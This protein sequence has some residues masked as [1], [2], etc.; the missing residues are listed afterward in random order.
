MIFSDIVDKIET[1]PYLTLSRDCPVKEAADQV[2]RSPEIRGIYVLDTNQ[3]LT[4]YLSLGILI[5]HV[6]A[7]QRKPHLHVRSLLTTI[8][9]ETVADIM[10]RNII[11][12]RPA[13][14]LE[15]VLDQM[16]T[17]NMKQVPI[18]NAHRQ[19]VT[20]AGILDIWKWMQ[21]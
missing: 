11:Y 4:G 18:V 8:T 17:R 3:C 6:V 10:E 2:I 14:T 15:S 20:A 21:R 1:V 16:L 9:A 7:A 5:R 13:D 12:A 19:I